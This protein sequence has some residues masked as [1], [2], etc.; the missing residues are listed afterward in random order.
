MKLGFSLRELILI[1]LFAAL[2]AVMALFVT[3]PLP[4]SPVPI[5][6]QTFG[7]MLAG[8]L[9]GSRKGA[10]SQVIYILLGAV[11]LP[12]FAGGMA[13]LSVLVGPRGGFLWGFVLGAFMIGK[14]VERRR[15]ITL[16]YLLL[17]LSLGGIFAVY[18]PGILQL[19]LVTAMTPAQAIAAML[20]WIPGDILKVAASA[21]LAQK[22]L[23]ISM[24]RNSL[25]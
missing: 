1:A 15:E 8:A 21:L 9:L 14:M 17:S 19:V 13:G 25:S 11:G 16:P 22:I 23:S 7:V 6:G 5:T 18:I 20:P 2:T 3:I 24:I 10:F 12:V 4:F